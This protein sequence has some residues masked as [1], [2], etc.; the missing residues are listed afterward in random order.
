MLKAYE[1]LVT[2]FTYILRGPPRQNCILDFWYSMYYLSCIPHPGLTAGAPT[3]VP[4]T[5]QYLFL[6]LH[7]WKSC[8]SCCNKVF[9]SSLFYKQ[10]RSDM[11]PR[12]RD[13]HVVS[14]GQKMPLFLLWKQS[15]I[16]CCNRDGFTTTGAAECLIL[17]AALPHRLLEIECQWG[18]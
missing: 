1:I 7:Q 2:V 13:S 11:L 16:F 12:Q 6:L 14:S 18:A 4:T 17:P 10:R 3:S 9:H 15:H 8:L 5:F